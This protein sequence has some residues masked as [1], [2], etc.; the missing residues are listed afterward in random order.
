M[1]RQQQKNDTYGDSIICRLQPR[2]ADEFL[3]T[4][5]PSLAA[6]FKCKQRKKN[7]Q[8]VK[9][10]LLLC[11]WPLCVCPIESNSLLSFAYDN[12]LLIRFQDAHAFACTASHEGGQIETCTTC[13]DTFVVVQAFAG[14][15]YYLLFRFFFS[16]GFFFH[17]HSRWP[18]SQ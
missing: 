16:S 18:L 14:R 10:T 17:A 15:N 1:R 12:K 11:V 3:I 5:F 2:L 13:T 7:R 9:N 4:F 6:S 8:P